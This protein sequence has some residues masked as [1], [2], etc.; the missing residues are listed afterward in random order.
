MGALEQVTQMK[1]QGISEDEIVTKLQEQ[2]ISPKAINDALNQ[3]QIKSAVSQPEQTPEEESMTGNYYPEQNYSQTGGA[4]DMQEYEQSPQNQT[5]QNYSEQYYPAE[6][7]YPQQ[8][9]SQE[10]GYSDYS[11]YSG[12]NYGGTDTFIEIAEQVFS[13]KIKELKKQIEELNEFKSL[14]QIKL[15][16]ALERLKRIENSLDKLQMAILDKVGSYGGTLE[17]IKKEMGMMQDSFGKA[18]PKLTEHHKN[19]PH[20]AKKKTT[21]RKTSKK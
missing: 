3:S 18:V 19:L 13:E 15:D 21:K 14:S 2:G 16:N 1:N 9:Y 10:G 7:E 17:S 20:T 8:N 4:Q 6:T 5:S 11:G 12:N